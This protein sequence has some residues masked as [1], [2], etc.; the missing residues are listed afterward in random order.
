MID[1]A[2]TTVLLTGGTGSFGQ[3][4]A[5]MMLRELRPRKLIIYS[6]DEWKQHVMRQDGF[7]APSMRYFLGDVRDR[8]RLRRAMHGVDVVVHAAALKQIPACEY[9][10]IE[11]VETNINGTR[12]VIDAALD[13]GVGRVLALSTDKATA[14]TNIYGATKLVAEKLV[15]QA[16][17]YRGELE[18]RFACVR[19][20]NVFGTRGSVVP[21]FLEQKASGR[22]TVTDPRMTRFWITLEQGVRFVVSCIERMHGGEVFVPKVPSMRILDLAKA[23]GPQCRIE[24][25]GIRSGEKVHES[26]ISPDEARLTVELPDRYVILPAH[27]T[28]PMFDWSAEGRPLPD[29]FA[30]TS[31]ANPQ[32]LP[33]AEVLGLLDEE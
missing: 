22:L 32:K 20:G 25:I 12:N 10:P 13:S 5:R 2:S 31:D 17:A 16:N 27:P 28:W 9:N 33:P 18:R 15:V 6:R 19:Y 7:D 26:L 8:D 21:L 11:A 3:A 29:G 14:P 30:Y 23:I 1:W 24:F 4:F